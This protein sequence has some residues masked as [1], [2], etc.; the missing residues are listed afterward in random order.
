ME[1][2]AH[3]EIVDCN[4]ERCT[5]S[6]AQPFCEI[7]RETLPMADEHEAKL[8]LTLARMRSEFARGTPA[9]Q[10]HEMAKSVFTHN[11]GDA[12]DCEDRSLA[13]REAKP[14]A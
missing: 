8:R 9:A 5:Y 3:A 13:A 6:P 11:L 1:K 12:G 14:S 10:A 7:A 4:L 2:P